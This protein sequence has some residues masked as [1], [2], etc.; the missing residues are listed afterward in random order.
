[1]EMGRTKAG[2]VPVEVTVPAIG[3]AIFVVAELTASEG[4]RAQA[5]ELEYK[6]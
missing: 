1:M 4:L 2:T 3:P 5:L 6:R